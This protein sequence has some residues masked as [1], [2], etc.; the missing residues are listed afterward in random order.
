M[1]LGLEVMLVALGLKGR[2]CPQHGG[3]GGIGVGG[4]LV[5]PKWGCQWDWG[6]RDVG[7]PNMGVSVG[8]GLEVMLVAL[9]LEVTLVALGLKG[10]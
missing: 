1:S 2:W 4:S 3:V 9:G 8:L 5:S 10:R 6:W 7:V